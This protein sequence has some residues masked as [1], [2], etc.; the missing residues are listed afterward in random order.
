MDIFITQFSPVSYNF[1]P[2]CPNVLLSSLFSDILNNTKEFPYSRILIKPF[3]AGSRFD[4]YLDVL[5]A[6]RSLISE[7]KWSKYRYICRQ[8][9][10]VPCIYTLQH[11]CNMWGRKEGHATCFSL[12]P[13]VKETT[14]APISKSNL[15]LIL[16]VWECRPAVGLTYHPGTQQRVV[17][18]STES[19]SKGS[20]GSNLHWNNVSLTTLESPTL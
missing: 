8:D 19:Q 16:H 13:V 20:K 5:E 1:T 7:G 6:P 4:T 10:A 14:V 3:Q 2:L 18:A 12:S 15:L 11:K 9:N 17:C